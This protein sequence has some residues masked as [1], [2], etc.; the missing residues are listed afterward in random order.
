LAVDGQ[1]IIKAHTGDLKTNTIFKQNLHGGWVIVTGYM[2]ESSSKMQNP[3]T[4]SKFKFSI[5]HAKCNAK[6]KTLSTQ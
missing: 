4:I 6:S 2:Q 3:N 1:V 5:L